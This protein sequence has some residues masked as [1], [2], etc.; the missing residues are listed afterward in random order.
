[1]RIDAIQTAGVGPPTEVPRR[2]PVPSGPAKEAKSAAKPKDGPAD[3]K[4]ANG[5]DV[6]GELERLAEDIRKYVKENKSIV[7]F[8]FDR[9]LQQVITKVLEEDT[10]KVIRQYPSDAAI[11]VM[12][13]LREIRGLL[14]HKKG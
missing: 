12:K 3:A 13:Q 6:S 11:G 2:G 8:S 10:G 7:D 14:I 1:M 5:A 9:D 4:P